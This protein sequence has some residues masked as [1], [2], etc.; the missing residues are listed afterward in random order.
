LKIVFIYQKK[1]N[2]G[3]VEIPVAMRRIAI[4]KCYRILEGV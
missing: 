2:L 3:A 1:N 4:A